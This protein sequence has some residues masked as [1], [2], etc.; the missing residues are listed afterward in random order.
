MI[1]VQKGIP[2]PDIRRR[3]PWPGMK[4]GD[5]FFVAGITP[6]KMSSNAHKALGPGNYAQRTVE[7]EGQRGVRVWRIK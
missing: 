3:Y 5:S 6:N 1:Q 7:E 2:V 4:V